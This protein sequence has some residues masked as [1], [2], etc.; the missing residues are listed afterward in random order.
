MPTAQTLAAAR[1]AWLAGAPGAWARYAAC[2]RDLG[3]PDD[4]PRTDRARTP[5]RA[6]RPRARRTA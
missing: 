5:R 3:A 1:A 4:P 2:L 6:A